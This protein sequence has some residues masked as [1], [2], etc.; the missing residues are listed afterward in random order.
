M[1]ADEPTNLR[2]VASAPSR[3]Q[4]KVSDAQ[5]VSSCGHTMGTDK[6]GGLAAHCGRGNS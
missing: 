3:G 6:L 4:E 5:G 1:M 2:W